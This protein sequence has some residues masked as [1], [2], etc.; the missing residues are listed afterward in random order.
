[1]YSQVDS[2]GHHTLILKEITDHRKSAIYVTI[3]DKSVVSKT[4]IKSFKNTTK[5]WDLLCLRKYGSTT[6]SQLKDIKE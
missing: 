5:V 6:W 3:Y 1:M 4:G 2:N